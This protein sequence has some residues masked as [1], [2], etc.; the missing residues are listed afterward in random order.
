MEIATG[1]RFH[2][3]DFSVQASGKEHV[4]GFVTLIRDPEH[5]ALWYNLPEEMIEDENGPPLFVFGHGMTIEE[6]VENAN[7][8]A[9]HAKPIV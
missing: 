4:T 3:A 6:A 8:M 9:R 2:A 5:Q 1:W 7:I